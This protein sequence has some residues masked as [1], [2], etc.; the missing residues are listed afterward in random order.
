MNAYILLGG[1]GTRVSHITK[2]THKSM[3]EFGDK[4]FLQYLVE[5][6]RSQKIT[7]LFFCVGDDCIDIKSYFGNGKK[8]GVTIN[9]SFLPSSY[10]TET[11]TS[12][13]INEY[14]QKEPFLLC[15]GDT[16]LPI[17]IEK[18]Q[19]AFTEHRTHTKSTVCMAVGT[20]PDYKNNL[21]IAQDDAI[22]YTLCKP[23]AL[24]FGMNIV[25]P[26]IF[27]KSLADVLT[28]STSSQPNRPI[29]SKFDDEMKQGNVYAYHTDTLFYEVGSE[30]GIK[31]FAEKHN[32]V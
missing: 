16:L 18:M 8:L 12:H 15:Y 22:T 25:S 23:N 9:Y 5:H 2:G 6:L 32:T 28:V 30:H 31:I 27:P 1:Y 14:R 26:T 29:S 7:N 24:E 10:E 19:I 17:N 20:H 4:P 3:L 13:A 21:L 11:R